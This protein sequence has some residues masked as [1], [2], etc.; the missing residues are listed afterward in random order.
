MNL[1]DEQSRL[2]WNDVLGCAPMVPCKF[3]PKG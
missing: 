2:T 1:R 3:P